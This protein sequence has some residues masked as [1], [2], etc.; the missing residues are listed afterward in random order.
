MITFT[1]YDNVHVN[2]EINFYFFD[3]DHSDIVAS[4]FLLFIFFSIN[5]NTYNE[6]LIVADPKYV[7]FPKKKSV[8]LFHHLRTKLHFAYTPLGVFLLHWSL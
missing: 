8:I 2:I 1:K 3:M 7:F 6:L 5:M 4:K